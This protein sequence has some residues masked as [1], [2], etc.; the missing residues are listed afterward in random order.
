MDGICHS[1]QWENKL[2]M[3]SGAEDS[4]SKK[5]EGGGNPAGGIGV[6]W[7]LPGD[8]DGGQ[9]EDL[10]TAG[11]GGVADREQEEG[12]GETVE[13]EEAGES[14][15]VE[16]SGPEA[17]EREILR[18]WCP[19]CGQELNILREHLGMQGSCPA[20]S[21][22]IV[23]RM[24]PDD[25]GS[26][27]VVAVEVTASGEPDAG[28]EPS[29][30]ETHLETGAGQADLSGKL[31]G[32]PEGFE[33]EGVPVAGEREP[34][35]G[36][37]LDGQLE[38]LK[39][40][41]ELSEEKLESLEEEAEPLGEDPESLEEE[42]QALGENT[43]SLQE[44]PEPL[45]E[46][47]ELLEEGLELSEEESESLEE[48]PQALGEEQGGDGSVE[49]DGETDDGGPEG[50]TLGR[51]VESELDL[52]A[53]PG[54]EVGQS[55]EDE[56]DKTAGRK[57]SESGEGDGDAPAGIDDPNEA[58]DVGG[59]D[60]G[61][62]PSW[63]TGG[64]PWDALGLDE[65]KDDGDV[66]GKGKTGDAELNADDDV[67]EDLAQEAN[68]PSKDLPEGPRLV[69]GKKPTAKAGEKE[70]DEDLEWEEDDSRLGLIVAVVI[71]LIVG[72]G[73][74]ALY[75][76]PNLVGGLA[77]VED[78]APARELAQAAKIEKADKT[79]DAGSTAVADKTEKADKTK[80]AG[81]TAVVDKT[82][83]A[84]KT[85]GAG[86][87]EAEVAEVASGEPKAIQRP[88]AEDKTPDSLEGG[89]AEPKPEMA[90]VQAE[91]DDKVAL[92]MHQEGE[93][94][95]R[96]F[97]RARS[98]EER[99][100]FVVD[101]GRAMNSMRSF[102]EKLGKLPTIRYMEFKGKIE[103]PTSG[104]R[105]GVFDVHERE[106]EESHRWIVVETEPGQY[107]LDWGLYEQLENSTLVAY[108]AREQSA[109]KK[110]RL[111]MKLGERVSAVDNPWD[112][113]AVKVFLQLPSAGNVEGEMVLVRK[114][115]A[116]KL[117]ILEGLGDGKIRIGR[118]TLDW[119]AGDKDPGSKAPTIIAFDGWGAWERL[120]MRG[121]N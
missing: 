12:G 34:N 98:V 95:I 88:E 72:G 32:E 81:S 110:F 59:G 66:D 83:K 109:P 55:G 71:I 57:P 104:L 27:R 11:T 80:D 100:T 42:P 112:E 6:P 89:G 30:G 96:S 26:M 99:A 35:Q 114:S 69:D 113:D 86:D 8:D 49:A 29:A 76:N 58:G 73:G 56:R 120:K 117:G 21:L 91:V 101:P 85:E 67:L 18:V 19:D 31:P 50:E 22:P 33:R 13:P 108:L 74:L 43:E 63:V 7:Y 115:E 47:L 46:E 106:N 111:L 70:L 2:G 20:C 41:L 10:D 3:N 78:K 45:G 28:E 14:S 61:S 102:Y 60:T 23:S 15:E 24:S 36:E 87:G 17:V 37:S 9:D 39:E 82:D 121:L 92:R 107:A 119:I 94:T 77:K 103:D 52:A 64:N 118:L 53:E 16:G 116:E 90:R 38:P 48:E 25:G 62:R 4:Q 105:F 54:E 93:R 75:L 5:G 97:Y 65:R 40:G 51:G 84:D 79:K 44:G 68:S 1:R